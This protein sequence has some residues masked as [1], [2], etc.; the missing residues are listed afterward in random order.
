MAI[1]FNLDKMLAS[2][3]M[4]SNDLADEFGCSVQTISKLKNGKVRALRIET[5]NRL[6]EIFDCQPGD[7]I[8]YMS[9]EE[10]R[11]NF[12]EKFMEDYLAFYREQSAD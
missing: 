9:V 8:E 1:I 11:K 4:Q 3:K 10:A 7:L 2:R 6:C 5:L 12:G